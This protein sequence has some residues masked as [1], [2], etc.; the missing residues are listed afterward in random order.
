[1]GYRGWRVTSGTGAA[2]Y[3]EPK[4]EKLV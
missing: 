3:L 1:V 4:L 2:S